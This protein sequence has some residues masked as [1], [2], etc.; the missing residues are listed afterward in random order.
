MNSTFRLEC[1]NFGTSI[2]ILSNCGVSLIHTWDNAGPVWRVYIWA[3]VINPQLTQLILFINLSAKQ[4]VKNQSQSKNIEKE[5]TESKRPCALFHLCISPNQV[6]FLHQLIKVST[7]T[8]TRASILNVW[9]FSPHSFF[10]SL[11]FFLFFVHLH[12]FSGYLFKCG[13]FLNTGNILRSE[14]RAFILE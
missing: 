13:Q 9:S 14:T 12:M 5:T 8:M 1:S 2:M 10:L 6:F 11:F 3:L 7:V 4:R